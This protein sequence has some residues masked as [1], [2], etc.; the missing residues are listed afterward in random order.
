MT[1]RVIFIIGLLLI[2]QPGNTIDDT[3]V[4]IKRVS[5]S[6]K[7]ILVGRGHQDGIGDGDFGV[8]LKSEKLPSGKDIFKP[9]A[10]LR[11]VKVRTGGSIWI[12]YKEL[13]SGE[14]G[15][16]KKFYLF[17]ESKLL[18]GRAELKG[19]RTNIVVEKDPVAEATDFLLE[20]D[21]LALKKEKYKPIINN[22]AKE[23]HIGKDFDLI[24]IDIWEDKL[25]DGKFT[26]KGI[27]RSPHI[28]EFAQRKRVH[29]FEKMVVAFLDKYNDPLFDRSEFISPEEIK[30]KQSLSKNSYYSAFMNK[31]KARLKQRE[32]QEENLSYYLGEKGEA[33]SDGLSDDELAK[34]LVNMNVINERQRRRE[35]LVYKYDTQLYLSFGL[36]VVN[37]ENVNDPETTEQS[38]FD[39][40]FGVENYS[41]KNFKTMQNFTWEYSGRRA[42]DAYFGGVLNVQ[43][44][45]YSA[46][47]G[48]NW[49]PF[50]LPTTIE[51]NIIYLSILT[52]YGI[53]RLSNNTTDEEGNY[54]VYTIPGFRAGVKYNLRNGFGFKMAL[55]YENIQS[56]RIIRSADDGTLPDTANYVDGKWSVGLTRFF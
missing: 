43:S 17:A 18:K 36:N 7:T 35:L 42:V 16:N 56:D 21:R 51:K 23:K 47:I 28:K 33:W 39:L 6:G 30:N 52:R 20:D 49:Y 12:V 22:H 25:N 32:L 26:P 4:T 41:F 5:K 38:K 37:N 50:S 10:K 34:L 19:K 13:I 15:E 44:I 29:T 8:L 11:A 31:Q 3:S 46:A 53:A 55:G 2:S 27:Y 48:L 14:I 45:E 9:V 24:D 40:E 1:L 54:Q